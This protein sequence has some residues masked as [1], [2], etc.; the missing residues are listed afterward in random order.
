MSPI[1]QVEHLVKR[2]KNSPTNA[3]DDISFQVA[4]GE[5]FVLLGPNGAGKT[6]TLSVLTTTLAP[7]LGKVE[8][9]GY[10]LTRDANR[11]RAHVGI[12][13]QQP[14]LD[15]NLTAEENVRLHA[16][17]YGLYPFRPAF[18]LMPRAYKTQVHELAAILGI[19]N[20]IHKPIKTLSGGM[21]RKLEIIRSLIHQPRVLFLDEPT[22]GLDPVSRRSLWDYLTRVRA[23]QET[24]IFLTTHYL[25]EAEQADTISILHHGKIVAQGTPAAVKAHLVENYLLVD[26]DDRAALRQELRQRQIAFSETPLFRID[27]NGVSAHQLLKTIDTP[28][29]TVKIHS[30]S[31][32]DAY[33][34]IIQEHDDDRAKTNGN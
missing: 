11:V 20:E 22:T 3:I 32:E 2:Y 7:T 27:L 19:A 28:L 24:T 8:I 16:N 30:P 21:K 4:A 18:W 25:E 29:T 26:A 10:D 15:Q 23:E 6:T 33:L 17:L 14:S 31:V 9:A 13:F 12:I 5:F 1:I 34:A